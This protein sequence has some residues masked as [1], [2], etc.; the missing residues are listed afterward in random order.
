MSDYYTNRT[1][2]SVL[3]AMR[4]CDK[5]KNYSYLLGM[6]EEAQYLA[7]KMEA[8]LYDMKDVRRLNEERSK[9]KVEVSNLRAQKKELG[10]KDETPI[11]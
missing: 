10:G 11:G 7:N 3:D 2:C 4:D 8:A 5:T 6:I 9:L 1:L